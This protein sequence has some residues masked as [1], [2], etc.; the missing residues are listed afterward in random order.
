MRYNSHM[1]STVVQAEAKRHTSSAEVTRVK[2][3]GYQLGRPSRLFPNHLHLTS[4][5]IRLSIQIV[6]AAVQHHKYQVVQSRL[7]RAPLQKQMLY[8]RL[9]RSLEVHVRRSHVLMTQKLTLVSLVA[10][11][12]HTCTEILKGPVCSTHRVFSRD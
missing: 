3:E 2:P 9:R 4:L 12:T 6:L 5:L 1:Q 11:M 7:S 8:I 10:T